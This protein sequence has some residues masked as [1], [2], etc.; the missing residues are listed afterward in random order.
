MRSIG[1]ILLQCAD[2]ECPCT[3]TKTWRQCAEKNKK[4][5]PF[6]SE[7]GKLEI[8]QIRNCPEKNTKTVGKD[9]TAGNGKM[10][11][12][13]RQETAGQSGNDNEFAG[14]KRNEFQ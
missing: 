3:V 12:I 14:G 8:K 9:L 10:Q 4:Q 2:I 5:F 7:C 6:Q 13:R 11:T 1:K